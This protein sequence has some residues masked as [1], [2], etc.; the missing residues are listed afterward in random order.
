[1]QNLTFKMPMLGFYSWLWYKVTVCTV[2]KS[3]ERTQRDL[4]KKK[5]IYI[6]I[7]IYIYLFIYLHYK[8]VIV[9]KKK[10]VICIFIYIVIPN[11][12]STVEGYLRQGSISWS[13]YPSPSKNKT[14]L[15]PIIP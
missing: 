6:Y 1:M 5:K 14:G 3:D 13:I 4:E 11:S 12:T 15:T 8:F 2:Q 9:K 7:Y 10:N